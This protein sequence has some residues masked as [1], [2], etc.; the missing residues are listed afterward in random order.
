MSDPNSPTWVILGGC[1]RS[2]TTLLN[3]LLNQHSQVQ[4]TNEHNIEYL[5]TTCRKLF[6]REKKVRNTIVRSKS[7]RENWTHEDI[8]QATLIDN[9]LT[10]KLLTE[11]Y[12][13]NAIELGKPNAKV[14]GDKLPRYYKL[15]LNLIKST[16]SNFVIIHV[17][18]NPVDV[19]NSM[20]RRA[21][22]TRDGTDYWK[23]ANNVWSACEEWVKAW[24]FCIDNE[25]ASNKL[26]IVKIKYE[27]LVQE[28]E[29]V[30]RN[31]CG[32]LSISTEI[33]IDRVNS[34]DDNQRDQIR[35]DE[36]DLVHQLLGIDD[37]EW[38]SSLDSIMKQR[39]KIPHPQKPGML[40]KISSLLSLKFFKQK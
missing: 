17:F 14:F 24:N 23:G 8:L 7:A 40:T 6:Y 19:V 32:R 21:S 38:N 10:Q 25:M 26:D 12:R 16:L 2:G 36:I 4:I 39:G 34:A 30:T 28:P 29:Q 1:P 31:I 20:L 15:D 18:R 5:V 22:N 35:A 9:G 11:L 37:L 3:L 27:D 33:D 13:L